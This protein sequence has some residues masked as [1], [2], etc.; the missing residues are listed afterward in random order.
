MFR[1]EA[2][3]GGPL[4]KFFDG[5]N[6]SGHTCFEANMYLAEDRIMC[7]EILI[8]RNEAWVLKYIPGC[9]ALTD[10]PDRLL[11][12]M[13]QR[14]RW[15][16]GS[17]FAAFYCILNFCKVTHSAHSYLRIAAIYIF[18]TYYITQ[19]VL[20]LVLVGSFYATFSILLDSFRDPEDPKKIFSWASL[21]DTLYVISHFLLIVV[22]S[23]MNLGDAGLFFKFFVNLY[24]CY[25]M[26]MVI[27][28]IVHL[29]QT[30]S[31]AAMF[32][33]IFGIGFGISY[34]LPILIN[35]RRVGVLKYGFGALTLLFLTPTYIIIMVIYAIC[36]IHDISWGNRPD[37]AEAKTE[38]AK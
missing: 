32:A 4:T 24:G 34:V 18:F 26:A 19:M 3:Q 11:V 30:L 37:T 6:K 27:M 22:S 16:N 15:I 20:T 31:L 38:T 9:K 1:W 17:M 7:L 33:L 28:A 13:K 35:F 29:T 5:L 10:P 2:I 14:R 36:N 25:I 21:L 8:K 23:T 12:L